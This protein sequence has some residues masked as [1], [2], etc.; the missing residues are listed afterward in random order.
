MENKV[1]VLFAA[2][3]CAP[4]IKVGG[5]GDVAGELPRKLMELRADVR[6]VIPGNRDI[7]VP[8][9]YKGDFPVKIGFRTETC[10]VRE[11]LKSP[12]PTWII[13]NYHYFGRPGVYGHWDDGERFAFFCLSIFEMLLKF[14]FKPDVVHL[15]D[16]HTAPL[17][18]LIREN[19][20]EQPFLRDTAIVYTIHN[21]EYQGISGR[22]V[23]DLFNVK[24]V[25]FKT[26]KVEYYGCFNAMKAGINYADIIN[27]V[28]KTGTTQM[29]TSKYGFGLEGVLKNR[30]SALRGVVNGIDI[31]FWNPENDKLIYTPF[32]KDNLS[33]KKENK[34]R[35]QKELG[36]DSSDGPLFGVVSRLV[37]N[38]GMDILEG[39]AHNIARSNGQFVLL[40][41][42]EK[43]YE[44]AFM[45][46]MER[47]PGKVSVNLEFNNELAH[48]IYAASDIFLMPSRH[49]PCGISQ[50]IAMR[51]GSVP[52][53]HK[54]G[55]LADTVI[56]TGR[57]KEKG[58]GFTF[59]GYSLESFL[60]AIKRALSLYENSKEWVS[61]V[62][63]AMSRDSSWESSA[64][65][66]MKLYEEARTLNRKR[67][68]KGRKKAIE[69]KGEG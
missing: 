65:E 63:R 36:L 67:K 51:Y 33:G 49:E 46:L 59:A 50:L 55:G 20:R 3:E 41:S 48:K 69:E 5:L 19:E 66:Y 23:F 30:K 24:D 37:P 35:L 56:D 2:A 8:S 42:G 45:R 6:V 28:S 64:A 61:L 7:N 34:K 22:N 39:A 62:K 32:N 57:N 40:G 12:V 68:T 16:W 14:D 52:I 60:K 31:D 29:L 18:M 17:S 13:D 15:N 4:I 38:K 44:N 11:V 21:L 27:G 1:K 9:V 54:T 47:Y 10:I 43:Y 25:V 58:T 26:D 53:V